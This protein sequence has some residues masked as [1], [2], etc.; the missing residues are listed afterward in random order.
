[1]GYVANGVREL[2]GVR[3]V[4]PEIWP[5]LLIWECENYMFVNISLL[6]GRQFCGGR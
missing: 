2:C 1:M 3:T 4:V 5:G 6:Y